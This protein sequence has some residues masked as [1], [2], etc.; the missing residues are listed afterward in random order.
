MKLRN[1]PS[2]RWSATEDVF[3]WLLRCWAQIRSSFN[4]EG[5]SFPLTQDRKLMLELRSV[6]HPLRF[7]QTA[8]QTTKEV[9]V[10]QVYLL[11][12]EAYFAVLDPNAAL[13]LYDPGQVTNMVTIDAQAPTHLTV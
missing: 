10:F 7:I 5:I 13:T 1:S 2:H 8:A 12:V 9:A 3:V 4:D 6:I 11:L